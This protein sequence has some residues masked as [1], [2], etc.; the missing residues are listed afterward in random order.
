M[1]NKIKECQQVANK[2]STRIAFK[3]HASK[4]YR[5]ARK[6][7]ILD[8]VCNH[9]TSGHLIWNFELCKIE[10]KKYTNLNDFQKN[11]SG[12]YHSARKSGWIKQICS[13]MKCG[14]TKWTQ[15]LCQIEALKYKTRNEFYTKNMGAYSAAKRNKWLNIICKHMNEGH[16]KW[17]YESLKLE[18][19]KYNSKMEFRR[20]AS[21]AYST[22]M[23]LKILDKICTHMNTKLDLR[24]KR[25]QSLIYKEFKKQFPSFDIKTEVVIPK[26]DNK[27]GRIDFLIKNPIN[28]KFIGLELKHDDSF[29]TKKE[30][31]IQIAKYNRAF[32]ERKGFVGV[33]VFSKEGKYGYNINDIKK[34]ITKLH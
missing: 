2:Y 10:A 34:I 33:Y 3:T 7:K 6:N 18:A 11:S 24:E 5:F 8:K 23:K 17:N 31:D 4:Y 1:K 13:H 9:M 21:G 12:A 32:R 26:R 15:Q 29:W 30:Q 19:L 25:L 22:A 27:N 20:K 28:G 16:T 14:L